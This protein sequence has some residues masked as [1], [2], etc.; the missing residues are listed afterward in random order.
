M[1]RRL[2]RLAVRVVLVMVIG[3]VGG[4]V[5]Q[6]A[7]ASAGCTGLGGNAWWCIDFDSGV[8]CLVV[9]AGYSCSDGSWWIYPA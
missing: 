3:T 9:P 7:P 8:G 6:Q 2:I 1:R 4:L 5:V